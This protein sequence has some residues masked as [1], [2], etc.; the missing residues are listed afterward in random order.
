MTA[1]KQPLTA[2]G[3]TVL[4]LL[5]ALMFVTKMAMAPLPNIEPVSLLVMVYTVI[6]GRRA[7]YPIYVYAV[8]E[9]LIWGINLWT[10]NYLYIWA[11]L[12][13]LAWLLRKM[14][15]RL[16]WAILSGAFGLAFG[17]LCA[18]V[19][20][21]VGGWKYALSWWVMGLPFDALHCG[22]NF[23]MALVLFPLCRKILT[24]LAVQVGLI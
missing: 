10:I 21:V 22:G 8:L 18:P 12:A 2:K 5:G 14:D 15:A 3:I 19:Y 24:K 13:G 16:G 11:V 1:K 20:L 7:L 4:G 9:C 6:F 17:A 23:V